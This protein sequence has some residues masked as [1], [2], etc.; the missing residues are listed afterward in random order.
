MMHY[1]QPG[2]S[3]CSYYS[4]ASLLQDPWFLQFADELG[5][6][7]LLIRAWRRGHLLLPVY[8]SEWYESRPVSEHVWRGLQGDL[9][10]GNNWHLHVTVKSLKY[11]GVMHHVGVIMEGDAVYVTDP[12]Q[13]DWITY[14]FESFLR[15]HYARVAYE[16]MARYSNKIADHP[17]V[18][19]VDYDFT[20]YKEP[21]DPFA[22]IGEDDDDSQIAA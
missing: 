2:R 3:G 12:G 7:R 22:L 17:V 21:I 14:P 4:L 10:E 15:S 5:Q 18:T 1:Q 8:A 9:G 19:D 6:E 11:Y 16:I 20:P 13:P